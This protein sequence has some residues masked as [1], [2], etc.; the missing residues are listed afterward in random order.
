[1]IK[2]KSILFP[3]LLIAVIIFLLFISSILKF[4]K[5]LPV[6]SFTK[7][8][9]SLFGACLAI[10]NLIWNLIKDYIESLFL[11]PLSISTEIIYLNLNRYEMKVYFKNKSKDKIYV[12][13]A[14]ILGFNTE[15]SSIEIEE[16]CGKEISFRVEKNTQIMHKKNILGKTKI[17]FYYKLSSSLNKNKFVKEKIKIPCTE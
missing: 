4:T 17:T 15:F 16:D 2:T 8:N 6:I 5:G 14:I 7:E 13:D 3:I 1:M 11:S 9:I 12:T 10:C